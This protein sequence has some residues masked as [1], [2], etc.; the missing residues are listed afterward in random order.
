MYFLD[1]GSCFFGASEADSETFGFV[2]SLGL[3]VFFGFDL[4]F[5]CCYFSLFLLFLFLV[6][7]Q[8]VIFI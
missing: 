8:C 2:R 5:F 3:F 1:L 7:L 6:I 4:M